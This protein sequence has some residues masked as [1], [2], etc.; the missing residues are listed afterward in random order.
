MFTFN[1]PECI[2]YLRRWKK[3]NL[4]LQV[5]FFWFSELWSC[6]SFSLNIPILA[7]NASHTNIRLPWFKPTHF[8]RPKSVKPKF[9]LRSLMYQVLFPKVYHSKTRSP[10]F[11]DT[12]LNQHSTKKGLINFGRQGLSWQNCL[13][14]LQVLFLIPLSDHTKFL[15]TLLNTTSFG[16]QIL[17]RKGLKRSNVYDPHGL[18]I[19]DFGR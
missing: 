7:F 3:N 1:V 2:R 19:L 13:F 9:G 15:P 18:Y 12:F 8:W 4:T 5:F 17:T 10:G 14:Q 16:P 11:E 6:L